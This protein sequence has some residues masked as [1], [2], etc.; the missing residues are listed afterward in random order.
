MDGGLRRADSS[1]LDWEI[2]PRALEGVPKMLRQRQSTPTVALNRKFAS[3][4][5]VT[6]IQ[7][8]IKAKPRPCT[9]EANHKQIQV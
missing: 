8:A 2:S 6:N 7:R 1:C 5:S 3:R 4:R 9:R